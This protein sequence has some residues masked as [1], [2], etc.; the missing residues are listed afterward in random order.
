MLDGAVKEGIPN[1]LYRTFDL[2]MCVQHPKG[3][4]VG[5]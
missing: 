4:S 1:K 2:M 5:I 3:W